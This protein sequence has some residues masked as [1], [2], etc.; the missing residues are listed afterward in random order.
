MSLDPEVLGIA[1]VE[2]ASAQ[3]SRSWPQLKVL[4]DAELRRLAHSLV[5]LA[6]K[7][8][9]GEIE[10]T[11]ARQLVHMHQ[12]MARNV[13]LTI[14]GIAMLTAEQAIDAGTRAV[15]GTINDAVK[16]KLL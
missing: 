2:A 3:V 12:V 11:H 14:K 4:A 9:N 7:V 8:S 13:L 16:L 5:D 10:A 6:D 15:A 1:M